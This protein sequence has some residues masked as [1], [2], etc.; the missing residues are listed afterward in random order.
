VY[1]CDG[2]VTGTL[3]A[4]YHG[5][6]KDRGQITCFTIIGTEAWL[7]VVIQ[8]STSP[9]PGRVGSERVLYVQDN[10]EG[11]MAEPDRSTGLA[12]LSSAGVDTLDEYC[13]TTPQRTASVYDLEAGNI[14]I[15]P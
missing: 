12:P 15:H 11:S 4:N 8:R 10:G 7:G 5:L 2:S 1:Y 9:N 14:Q 13:E 3:Q 6:W